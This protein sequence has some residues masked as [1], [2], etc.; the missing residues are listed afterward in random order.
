MRRTSPDGVRANRTRRSVHTRIPS[1]LSPPCAISKPGLWPSLK[2][3][4]NL[5]DPTK[6][7]LRLLTERY[8][9]PPTHDR[10][11]FSKNLYPSL[12]PSTARAD[13]N[14]RP[15][16]CSAKPHCALLFARCCTMPGLA[17][18]GPGPLAILRRI[19]V[20]QAEPCAASLPHVPASGVVS[21][22]S[23]D[24]THEVRR[25]AGR[26]ISSSRAPGPPPRV[27]ANHFV[28]TE[29]R[30]GAAPTTPMR[31]EMVSALRRESDVSRAESVASPP[32]AA[33]RPRRPWAG[34][35]AHELE[36]RRLL[37]VLHARRKIARFRR[38]GRRRRPSSATPMHVTSVRPHRRPGVAR[39]LDLG[40]FRPFEGRAIRAGRLAGR[41]RCSLALITRVADAVRAGGPVAGSAAIVLRALDLPLH[42]AG[43]QFRHAYRRRRRQRPSMRSAPSIPPRPPRLGTYGVAPRRFRRFPVSR[44]C[45]QAQ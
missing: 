34:L 20:R 27:P 23:D 3:A 25:S 36:A 45:K 38:S 9:R 43:R 37:P 8:V 39:T 24:A 40:D 12:R 14:R 13:A 41:V 35:R 32:S 11:S 33:E 26:P 4:F 29:R 15:A 5:A 28:R 10:S 18:L 22:L 1:P 17:G 30:P 42:Q 19:G 21:S 7:G 16:A 6:A 2:A 31:P 44:C